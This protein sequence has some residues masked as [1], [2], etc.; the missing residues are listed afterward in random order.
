MNNTILSLILVAIGAIIAL[1]G[2]GFG[3]WIS[4]KFTGAFNSY[5]V[6]T[7]DDSI[8]SI[9]GQQA[10]TSDEDSERVPWLDEDVPPDGDPGNNPDNWKSA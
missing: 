3:V 10:L 5:P 1:S 2:V 6:D 8:I 7:I 4:V 9:P